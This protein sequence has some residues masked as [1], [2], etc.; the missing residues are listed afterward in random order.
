MIFESSDN[1][2]K[3]KL[4]EVEQKKT[5]TGAFTADAK[6]RGAESFT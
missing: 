1:G 3:P 6:W 2:P 4:G 5:L